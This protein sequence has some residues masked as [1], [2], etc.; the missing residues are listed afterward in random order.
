[1][2]VGDG[3]ASGII[4][5]DSETLGLD[6]FESEA[7]TRRTLNNQT[8]PSITHSANKGAFKTQAHGA[9]QTTSVLH[10]LWH[11]IRT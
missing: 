10:I 6:I 4:T 11:I 1:V 5:D 2:Q 9:P 7:R 3:G 8:L